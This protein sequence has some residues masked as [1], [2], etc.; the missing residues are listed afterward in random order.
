MLRA[1][2]SAFDY[3]ILDLPPIGPA[4]DA[5][6]IAQ[7]VDS[8]L[9]VVEWGRTPKAA[10]ASELRRQA[11]IRRRLMGVVLNKVEL[12]KLSLY[13]D[14]MGSYGYAYAYGE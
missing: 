3:V 4:V 6:A 2:S 9:L 13:N 11:E 8:F 1:L 14:T 12:D 10:V 5:K 7:Y